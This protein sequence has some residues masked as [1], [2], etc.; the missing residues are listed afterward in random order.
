MQGLIAA[1]AVVALVSAVFTT[2]LPAGSHPMLL[3]RAA[4]W[5]AL[6]LLIVRL[7]TGYAEHE[8]VDDLP[9][10]R[11]IDWLAEGTSIVL[12]LLLFIVP[13]LGWYLRYADG[14]DETGIALLP[15]WLK[16]QRDPDL[17]YTLRNLHSAAAWT[18]IVLLM[19]RLGIFLWQRRQRITNGDC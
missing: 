9:D 18:L 13:L 15:P 6:G 3:H 14:H 2:S 12:R 16:F 19:L 1:A 17:V 8:V 7:V 5:L 11:S 10:R 4:G